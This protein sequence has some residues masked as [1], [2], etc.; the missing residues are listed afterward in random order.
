M[1][2][3]L[4][5]EYIDRLKIKPYKNNPRIHPKRQIEQIMNSIK[6][7][8]FNVPIL[9]DEK[10]IIIAGH[11]R[12]SASE[13]LDLDTVPIVQLKHL[14]ES[15]KKAFVIA[16]NKLTE[17][18]QWDIDM[19]KVEL[20]DLSAIE[21]L[22]FNLEITGFRTEEIDLILLDDSQNKIDEKTNQIP[23]ICE[24][25]IVSKLG[26]TW[27]LG[28]HRIIC[29][30]SLEEETYKK[31]LKNKKAD[32]IL[33]DPPYNLSIKKEV[34]TSDLHKE[35]QMASGEMTSEEFQ[36]FLRKSF[37]LQKEYSRNGS[38][39][40]QFMDWRN[41]KEIINA[42][43]EVYDD[44]I[45]LCV[46]NKSNAGMGS[47]FRSKHEL[48]FIFKNGKAPHT[49]NINLGANGNYRTNV[50]DYPAANSF[51]NNRKNLK[52]H[53]T[54]KNVELLKDAILDVTKRGEIVLD[55]F[56]G[57]GST[58][59]AAEK[60]GRI[61]YGIEIEPLYIDTTI[62]RWE[63]LTGKNAIHISSGKTYKQKLKGIKND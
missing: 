32:M 16:D 30:N 27:E 46:W 4:K 31:L 17:N 13:Q 26:D 3:K 39:H 12:L 33:V 61:C 57:S 20:E 1:T 60:V 11:A 22:D 25:E 42:G 24:N 35:F 8:G 49:N 28:K 21:N 55:S 7:F 36:E 38:L 54:P 14:S 6:S 45:N 23:F 44:F 2:G 37:A 51:G 63:E 18:G 15:Q 34:T 53:P 43:A 50:W 59:L 9:V 5:V 52:L 10:Y 58:L 56:L 41:I 47:L 40:F 19:L 48:V 29:G 62:R